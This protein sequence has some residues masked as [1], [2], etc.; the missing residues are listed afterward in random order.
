MVIAGICSTHGFWN[1]DG[2]PSCFKNEV[3]VFNT[4]K[5]QLYQFDGI[6]TFGKHTEVRGKDHWKKLLKQ[7]G[8][9]DDIKGVKEK[10]YKP[11]DRKFIAE[12]IKKELGEKGLYHKLV[13]RRKR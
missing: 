3:D 5:D 1:G 4:T 9:I 11:T 10:P 6:Q 12:E 8:L 13:K 7:H 2:C